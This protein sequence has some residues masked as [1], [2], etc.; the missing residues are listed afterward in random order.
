MQNVSKTAL[1]S[2]MQPKSENVT[3]F[4]GPGTVG[5][6]LVCHGLFALFISTLVLLG[7]CREV[8]QALA[9]EEVARAGL[10]DPGLILIAGEEPWHSLLPRLHGQVPSCPPDFNEEFVIGLFLGEK[11][12]G[13]YSVQ[14]EEVEYRTGQLVL[15]VH[16]VEP[17]PKAAVVMV[18]TYPGVII[19]IKRDHLPDQVAKV[20]VIDKGTGEM[21]HETP[22]SQTGILSDP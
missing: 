4:A 15:K 11:P 10:P 16:I 3:R 8:P 6:S 2:K 7:G 17:P 5:H 13:G 21:L 20:V 19:S 12:T 14:V 1:G 22:L 18:L 9:F